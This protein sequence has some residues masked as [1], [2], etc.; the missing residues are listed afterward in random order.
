M[1]PGAATALTAIALLPLTGCSAA[2]TTTAEVS[3]QI[4]EL[5]TALMIT[6][7]AAGVEIV[8]GD[9]P[10]TVT[11]KHRYSKGKADATHRVD[12]QTLRLTDAGCGDDELRCEIH[13]AIRIPETA[14]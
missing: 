7:R 10:V 14:H 13:Y 3:Y 9:G 5:P 2:S 4:D 11:E 1:R 6:A 8:T 12:G